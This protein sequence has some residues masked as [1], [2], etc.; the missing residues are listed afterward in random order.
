MAKIKNKARADGRICSQIYLRKD[1]NGKKMYK[2][3]YTKSQRE[4]EEKITEIK[5]RLGKGIDISAERDT[6]DD[7]GRRW[8]K[9]KQRRVSE[10]RYKALTINYKKLEAIYYVPVTQLRPIDIEEILDSLADA[11]YSARIIRTV[12]DIGSGVMQ[13]CLENRVIDYNPFAVAGMPEANPKKKTERRALNDEEQR[14]IRE[15]PHRA[16]TAAM[17]MMYA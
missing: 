1:E 6:F 2:T 7:W 9:K 16:Q 13:M 5:V 10:S 11:G 17:I 12:R 4:L 14:W 3:V 15:T 8:L